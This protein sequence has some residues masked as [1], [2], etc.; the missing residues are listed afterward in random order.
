MLKLAA[1]GFHFVSLPVSITEL[2]TVM[3]LS[4]LVLLLIFS[5]I[6]MEGI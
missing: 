3:N 5:I 4:D 2:F 1:M 6:L